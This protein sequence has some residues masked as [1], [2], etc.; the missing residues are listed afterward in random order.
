MKLLILTYMPKKNCNQVNVLSVL[1]LHCN[2]PNS[3]DS[4]IHRVAC[5]RPALHSQNYIHCVSSGERSGYK[6]FI[7]L[8]RKML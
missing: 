2:T 8:Q 7:L 1:Y 4:P 3:V 5:P 6:I